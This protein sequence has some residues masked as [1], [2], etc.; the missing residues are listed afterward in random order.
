MAHFFAAFIE[1]I[2]MKLGDLPAGFPCTYEGRWRAFAA[3]AE[4]LMSQRRVMR[5]TVSRFP[6]ALAPLAVV[7]ITNGS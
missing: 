7:K 2:N 4:G 6:F 5:L 3:N 1:L